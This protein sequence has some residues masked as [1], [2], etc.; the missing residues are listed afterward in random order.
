MPFCYLLAF[1]TSILVESPIYLLRQ[2]I[3][4]SAYLAV[5]TAAYA[6]LLR[7][8]IAFLFTAADLFFEGWDPDPD[9][10]RPST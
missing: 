4:F 5:I 3:I 7:L 6:I 9:A 1:M 10:R 2:I 8:I